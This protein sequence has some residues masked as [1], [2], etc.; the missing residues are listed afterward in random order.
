MNRKKIWWMVG[1]ALLVESGLMLLPIVAGLCFGE[2][3]GAYM[4]RRRGSC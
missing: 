4:I 2:R 3:P 1:L